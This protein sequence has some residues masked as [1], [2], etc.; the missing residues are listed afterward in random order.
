MSNRVVGAIGAV[1]AIIAAIILLKIMFG[2]MGILM[3]AAVGIL[4]GYVWGRTSA[5]VNAED[6]K[7][8]LHSVDSLQKAA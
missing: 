2:M 4:I 5:K 8:K 6:K 3:P 7:R 1:V